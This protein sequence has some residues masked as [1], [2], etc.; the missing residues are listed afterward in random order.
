MDGSQVLEKDI[1][2]CRRFTAQRG[3]E[4]IYNQKFSEVNPLRKE[5]QK[6][7]VRENKPLKFSHVEGNEVD[8][9]K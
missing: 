3:R 2:G 7:V 1:L 5:D 6:P 9:T 8:V 4:R